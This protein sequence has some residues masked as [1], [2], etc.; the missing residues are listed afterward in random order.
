M[1]S[2]ISTTLLG[3][4]AYTRLHDA[5]KSPLVLPRSP[6]LRRAD[7]RRASRPAGGRHL[8]RRPDRPTGWR[9]RHWR[10]LGTVYHAHL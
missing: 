4:A 6:P 3:G 8:D 1:S 7:P 9:N 10:R 5:C 2:E